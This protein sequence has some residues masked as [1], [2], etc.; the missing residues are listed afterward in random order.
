ML[1]VDVALK[2]LLSNFETPEL[3]SYVV[4]NNLLI[5]QI[6]YGDV[7]ERGFDPFY[8]IDLITEEVLDF[9]ILLETSEPVVELFLKNKKS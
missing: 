2:K 6:F 1:D 3:R 8:S 7:N 4:Y 9:P 5:A